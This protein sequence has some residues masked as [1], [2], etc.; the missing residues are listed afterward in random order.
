MDP[1][2]VAIWVA[3][4]LLGVIIEAATPQLVA[5]WFAA[6]GVVALLCEVFGAPP[7]AQFIVFVVLSGILVAATR[8]LARKLVK[9]EEKTNADALI[10]AEA[11]VTQKIDNIRAEG[12]C[13]V[14]GQIWSARAADGG[15][16]DEG[17]LVKISAIEGVKLIVTKE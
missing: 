7:V 13:K 9:K 10:G 6:A 11:L 17:T 3:V 2:V 14:N 5:I 4:I 12:L 1:I 15:V 16:I 8:P